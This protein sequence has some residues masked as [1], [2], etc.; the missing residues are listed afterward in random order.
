M[1]PP[2]VTQQASAEQGPPNEAFL[3][4]VASEL[5]I[6]A[7]ALRR[8]VQRLDDG[9]SAP[10][11]ARYRRDDTGGLDEATISKAR[12]RL[13]H[14]RRLAERKASILRSLEGQAKL[15]DDLRM[16]LATAD[17]LHKLEDLYLPLKPR[18]ASPAS[19]AIQRGLGTL[20]D[21]IV[22]ESPA[23]A[24]L[25]A[26]LADFVDIDKKVAN[27][28]DALAGAGT[29][30]TERFSE[31]AE[32]RAAVR[33]VLQAT[34]RLVCRRRAG[35]ADK[36]AEPYK[37]YFEYK[38]S[39]DKTPAHRVMA[40]NR[41]ERAG[42]LDVVIE[43][44]AKAAVKLATELLVDP[45][46]AHAEFLQGCA[47]EAV[48]RLVLPSLSDEARRELDDDAQEHSLAVFARNLKNLLLAP[49]LPGR[50]VLG[51]DP[52]YKTGCHVAALDE[53]G[54]VLATT[55]VTV[56]G[57]DEEVAASRKKLAELV[58]VHRIDLI[59]IGNG[60]ACRPTE[61]FV[62]AMLAEE[63]TDAD[64]RYAIVNE[65]GA[66][67]YSTSTIGREELPDLD[68]PARCAVSIGRRL[69][70][71]LAEL[72]KIDPASVGVGL[73]QHDLRTKP[74]TD[75]LEE[76]VASCVSHVGVDA[77]TASAALLRYVGGLN[78][79]TARRLC[80][81]RQVNGPLASREAIR[82]AAGLNEKQFRL[83][84]G[85]LKVTGGYEPLDATW[86]HPDHYATARQLLV[87]LEVD[88]PALLTD[89]GA[90][91]FRGLS[92]TRDR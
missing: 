22:T 42:A 89:D 2:P 86:V 7:G 64:T 87:A 50:R 63:L 44:D 41:G 39:L 51:I 57:S 45:T 76:V 58:T 32:V 81:A 53:A 31:D 40:I 54:G 13:L 25:D 30:L 17:S 11:I 75:A 74:M 52:G 59:A 60:K 3:D 84:A 1:N 27:A 88:A 9:E 12:Q 85:F 91:R 62:A 80:E 67:V 46:H 26:R 10:F 65:A 21:E 69:Q 18:K 19:E 23:T 28:A 36:K 92:E 48:R 61:E 70:D 15:T 35:V 78:Q 77:N 72:V 55:P 82:E 37:G 6:E 16:R 24:N 8:V 71:P 14:E 38:A 90:E 68:A 43:A 29:I 4:A 56:V 83:A 66:S 5:K 47:A 20:V 33:G 49:P 34:G 73:Y 79:L